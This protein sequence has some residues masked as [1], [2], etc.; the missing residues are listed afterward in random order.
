M[1]TINTNLIAMKLIPNVVI[2]IVSKSVVFSF[3]F[4]SVFLQSQSQNPQTEIIWDNYGVPHIICRNTDEMYY[5]FGWAQM[6]NDANLLLKLYGQAQGRA[7]EYWGESY[8]TSDIQV[9][10]FNV[11]ETA[12]LHYAKQDIESKK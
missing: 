7:A 3:F 12:K 11:P 1:S 2:P 5:A 4:L 10:L 6:H 9:H 8:L